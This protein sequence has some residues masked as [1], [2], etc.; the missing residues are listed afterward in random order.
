MH[1]SGTTIEVVNKKGREHLTILSIV[2]TTCNKNEK[3]HS[4]QIRV[5]NWRADG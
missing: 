5:L 3:Q 4:A 1:L 2:A